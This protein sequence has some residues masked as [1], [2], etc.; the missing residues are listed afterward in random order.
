M[1]NL[2]AFRSDFSSSTNFENWTSAIV[3]KRDKKSTLIE[4]MNFK[5][6]LGLNHLPISLKK[7]IYQLFKTRFFIHQVSYWIISLK[8]VLHQ[9]CSKLTHKRR[10]VFVTLFI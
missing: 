3:S 6:A 7:D 8:E 5:I 9:G 10:F 2:K 1:T 4:Q